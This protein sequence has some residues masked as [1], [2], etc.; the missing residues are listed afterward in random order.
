MT[1]LRLG[2]LTPRAFICDEGDIEGRR[3]AD[4]AA[5]NLARIV[6]VEADRAAAELRFQVDA[7][8]WLRVAFADGA[9]AEAAA[10]LAAV[11]DGEDD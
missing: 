6:W 9:F 2:D 10:R 4:L 11:T 5:V 1:I 3:V 8:R 7:D